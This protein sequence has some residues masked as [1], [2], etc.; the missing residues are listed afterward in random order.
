MYNKVEK[1]KKIVTD[2]GRADTIIHVLEKNDIED[3]CSDQEKAKISKLK[4]ASSFTNK[5]K[6][7]WIYKYILTFFVKVTIYCMSS[8]FYLRMSINFR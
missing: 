8:F 3:C 7:F 6:S 1:E 4:Y 2:L 5:C